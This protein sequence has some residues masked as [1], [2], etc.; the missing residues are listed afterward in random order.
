MMTDR[1]YRLGDISEIPKDCN[2]VFFDTNILKYVFYPM[3]DVQ[4]K[5]VA[6]YT[7]LYKDI[8]L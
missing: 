1:L 5:P 8:L 4:K 6:A 3:A 7:K 2:G